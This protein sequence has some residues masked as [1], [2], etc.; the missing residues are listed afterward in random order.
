MSV[1]YHFTLNIGFK[2]LFSAKSE[3]LM[4]Y[5]QSVVYISMPHKMNVYSGY[6]KMVAGRFL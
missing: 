3:E 4:S 6:R 5:L 1:C 2:N